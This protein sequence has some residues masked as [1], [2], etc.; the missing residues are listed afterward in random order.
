MS[1]SVIQPRPHQRATFTTRRPAPR[2]PRWARRQAAQQARPFSRSISRR[3]A[4]STDP[5]HQPHVIECL[6]PDAAKSTTTIVPIRGRGALRRS[7]RCRAVPLVRPGC[8]RAPSRAGSPRSGNHVRPCGIERRGIRDVE[9]HATRIALVR[10]GLRLRLEDHR[11]ADPLSD[12]L[13]LTRIARERALRTAMP[14]AAN[15]L[16]SYSGSVPRRAKQRVD[17]CGRSPAAARLC[18][19]RSHGRARVAPVRAN[20]ARKLPWREMRRELRRNGKFV[21]SRRS[22]RLAAALDARQQRMH[23]VHCEL[24]RAGHHG[25]DRLPSAGS[26]TIASAVRVQIVTSRST[27]A[28]RPPIVDRGE[29]GSAALSVSASREKAA[30]VKAMASQKSSAKALDGAQLVMMPG[31][32]R[33]ARRAPATPRYRP[34]PPAYRP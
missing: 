9:R 21:A 26:A 32:W 1:I 28:S 33:P 29:S 6:G 30:N 34:I 12:L 20:A 3:P 31:L 22:R 2:R 11:I 10:E 23:L 16:P 18:P 17:G 25:D 27:C 8:R 14:S 4:R 13:R 5:P 24:G 19:S 15:R 7:S